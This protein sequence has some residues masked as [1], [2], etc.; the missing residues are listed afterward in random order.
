MQVKAFLSLVLLTAITAVSAQSP[1]QASGSNQASLQQE[2]QNQQMAR[3]AAAVATLIDQNRI[4]EVWDGASVVAKQAA[5]RDAFVKQITA[6]RH[7]LGAVVER[8]VA[9]VTYSQSDGRQL[10]PGIYANVV[11]AARFANT[12]NTVRE[13]V[14]FH[15]DN[16]HVWRVAG[17]TLR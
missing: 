14:S 6:D 7:I 1:P 16:D 3:A 13:L 11:F 9:A 8:R 5:S 2:Q 10:P 17:Y 15:F 12:K 4:A